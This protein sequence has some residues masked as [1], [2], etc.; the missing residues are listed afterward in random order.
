MVE[1]ILRKY[2]PGNGL[3]ASALSTMLFHVYQIDQGLYLLVLEVTRIVLRITQTKRHR[4]VPTASQCLLHGPSR[5]LLALLFHRNDHSCPPPLLPTPR[6]WTTSA[7]ARA[8]S[9]HG[10]PSTP[11]DVSLI[12]S[13]AVWSGHW[14]KALEVPHC[15]GPLPSP[16]RPS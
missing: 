12:D 14:T 1:A 9:G 4:S 13:I 2:E 5:S 3:E 6:P 10:K 11:I 8:S 16:R 7:S 15:H